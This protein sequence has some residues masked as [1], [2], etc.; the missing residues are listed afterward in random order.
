MIAKKSALVVLSAAL[1]GGIAGCSSEESGFA[2]SGNSN[3]PTPG[4][5]SE[6][7]DV[8][9]SQ[10]VEPCDLLSVGDLIGYG[11][12]S[13]GEYEEVGGARTCYW[14]LSSK[15]GVEGFI[16]SLN[17]RD[18]QNV[19]SMND[20]GGGVDKYDIGG[21]VAARVVN[22]QFGDCTIALAIDSQSRVDV[23]VNG[24]SSVDDS[25]PVAEEVAGKVEPRL[26]E[27]P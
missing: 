7:S 25:C 12:F 14:Q 2:E 3:F 13:E 10:S 23:V 20:V 22:P 1:L 17:V 9:I 11:D 27:L 16:V 5:S 26:P 8:A 6:T 18:A 15:G 24:L 4:S 19:D 21:R